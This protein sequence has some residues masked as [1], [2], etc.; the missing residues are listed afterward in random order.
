MRM[1]ITG[2]NETW[3][4]AAARTGIDIDTLQNWNPE[5]PKDEP[6]PADALMKI[7][8]LTEQTEVHQEISGASEHLA[9]VMI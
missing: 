4:E 7:P 2:T 9:E 8:V 1:M 5:W 3:T 6:L